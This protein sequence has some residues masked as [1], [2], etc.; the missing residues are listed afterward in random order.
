MQLSRKTTR[1]MIV[2]LALALVIGG[3][4]GA[5]ALSQ[6]A[7][8]F[9][10]LAQFHARRATMFEASIR[11]KRRAA[12]DCEAYGGPRMLRIAREYRAEAELCVK[13]AAYHAQLHRKYQRAAASAWLPVAVDP[14]EPQADSK[15]GPGPGPEPG[16]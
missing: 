16:L 5:R 9:R 10:Q 14:P 13:L 2:A 15:P 1:R 12:Q 4:V 3:Y 11:S 8:R 6:R 7:N